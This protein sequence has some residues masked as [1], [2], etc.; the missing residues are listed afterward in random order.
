MS[1]R[2]I[3]LCEFNFQ[4][5]DNYFVDFPQTNFRDDETRLKGTV[6]VISSDPP[7]K[8]GNV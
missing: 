8:D 3:G 5:F 2:R 4:G 1:V 7:C 6:S